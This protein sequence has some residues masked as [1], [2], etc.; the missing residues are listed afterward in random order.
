MSTK[1]TW[2]LGLALLLVSP[3]LV[4]AA[5]SKDAASTAPTTIKFFAFNQRPAAMDEV[6]A[7]AERRMAST[8]NIKL[9]WILLP[10][11]Q[12]RPKK[13]LS[14]ASGEAND[15]M[16]DAPWAGMNQNIDAGY[17]VPL[18]DLLEKYGQ[19]IIANHGRQ[20][21]DN[22]KFNGKVMGLPQVGWQIGAHYWVIRKDIREKIGFPAIKSYQDL[23]KFAY[24]VKAK[25]P[26]ITPIFAV[27]GYTLFAHQHLWVEE[28]GTPDHYLWGA[29]IGFVDDNLILYTTGLKPVIK[30]FLV[31]RDPKLWGWI[32]EARKLYLDGI[33]YKDMAMVNDY[34]YFKNGKF[35]AWLWNDIGS[36]RAYFGDLKANAPGAD[37]EYVFL[38]PLQ[39]G[40]ISSDFRAWNFTAIAT[41][42]KNKEKAMQFLDWTNIKE[43]YDLMVYGIEGKNWQ[44]VG[45][46]KYRT[47]NQD[48]PW[49]SYT[50]SWN[51]KL[52]RINAD[53]TDAEYQKIKFDM[54]PNNFVPVPWAGFIFD[55]TP[56]ANEVAQYQALLAKYYRP[57]FAGFGDPDEYY[58]NFKKDALDI[59]VKIQ[60]ELQKQLDAY[61]ARK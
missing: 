48:Y 31:D 20:V 36:D 51:S 33:L 30:N 61:M 27:D 23:I 54:D 38:K 34:L 53:L 21:I 37:F 22:N 1:R 10:F 42:S 18:D 49:F 50:F 44:A 57:L 6:V 8:L 4:I 59:S 13:D 55:T 9:D 40:S 39:K 29:Q 24:E 32:Q 15:I 12:W 2:L 26:D 7:E 19:N 52:S 5:G 56:V 45:T 46:D 17:Y 25:M 60:K 43:N 41:V 28:K 16:F 3:A 11:D 35:A 58:N 47:L 14:L